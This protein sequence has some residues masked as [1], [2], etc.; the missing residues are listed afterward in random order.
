MIT[1]QDAATGRAHPEDEARLKADFVEFYDAGLGALADAAV[2]WVATGKGF[3]T[4]RERT[5]KA[6]AIPVVPD[7]P[8][9]AKNKFDQVLRQWQGQKYGNDNRQARRAF[10]VEPA[11]FEPECQG[12]FG[13]LL[14]GNLWVTGQTTC[15]A[16]DP[17][18]PTPLVVNDVLVRID[19]AHWSK[20]QRYMSLDA[21]DALLQ[22]IYPGTFPALQHYTKG[23]NQLNAHTIIASL[24]AVE[25]LTRNA[26]AICARFEYSE[27]LVNA[28]AELGIVQRGYTDWVAA[29]LGQKPRQGSTT[30]YRSHRFEKS[31]GNPAIHALATIPSDHLAAQL[32]SGFANASGSAALALA[33]LLALRGA[34]AGR[35]LLRKRLETEKNSTLRE[36]LDRILRVEIEDIFDDETGYVALDGSRV[37]IAPVPAIEPEFT[38]PDSVRVDIERY[39][40]QLNQ[41]IT[42]QNEQRRRWHEDS[43][44]RGQ[45]LSPPRQDALHEAEAVDALLTIAHEGLPRPPRQPHPFHSAI[46]ALKRGPSYSWEARFKAW[47][48]RPLHLLQLVR[49]AD[50][51]LLD[52]FTHPYD[53]IASVEVLRRLTGVLELRTLR[54]AVAA[55]GGE[56]RP[57]ALGAYEDIPSANV[58]P[59]FA[60]HM[61]SIARAFANGGEQ[62]AMATLSRFPKVPKR[63]VP[64]LINLALSEKRAQWSPA[65]T[66]LGDDASLTPL[67]LPQ[68]ESKT[69]ERRRVAAQW[70]G[71]RGDQAAVAP[72]RAA[73]AKEKSALVYAAILN[74][75]KALG[76]ELDEYFD[77]GKL[78]AAAEESLA[79]A[80]P[81]KKGWF[82][83]EALP[84]LFW[85]D[86]RPLKR[87]LVRHWFL[88]A[89]ELKLT[90]D[91]AQ[92]DLYLD[93]LQPA[94]AEALGLYV[95]QAWIARDT[96]PISENDL[97][98]IG[99]EIFKMYQATPKAHG[100]YVDTT[101]ISW[102]HLQEV[103]PASCLVLARQH[104]AGRIVASAY[105]NRG[106]LAIAAR[107]PAMEAVRLIRPYLKDHYKRMSQC[108]ALLDCL[109]AN[110]APAAL[111]LIFATATKSKNKG[112]QKHASTLVDALA[113]ARGW[114]RDELA[115]RTVP[116]AG[117]DEEGVLKL[118]VGDGVYAARMG[119]DLSTVLYN[120]DGVKVAALPTPKDEVLVAD[121]KEAKATLSAAKKELKQ[122]IE[123]QSTRF[124]EALCSE[125]VWSVEDFRAFILQ[126]PILSRLAERLIWLALDVGHK[127]ATTFRPLGDGTLSDAQ[128]RPV[129]LDHAS[130]VQLAH[131]AAIGADHAEAWLRHFSDYE[132]KPLF[133]QLTRPRRTLGPEHAEA[134]SLED[135]QGWAM[136]TFKLRTAATKLGW[137]RGPILDG[138]SF[139]AYEKALPGMGLTAVLSFSGSMVP[140][141]NVRAA[142]HGVRFTRAHANGSSPLLLA[143]VP[144]VLLSEVWNDYHDIA[145][146]GAFD[147]EWE[148]ICP[149]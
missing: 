134:E 147:P 85:A 115:D 65:Q 96:T 49:L 80:D 124:Y 135:R 11:R 53:G 16:Y 28:L 68:L 47:S 95:L 99:A 14:V 72:L 43:K 57:L 60:A 92:I 138:G 66:L 3:E 22:A 23:Q 149:W 132:L 111:Q 91:N 21:K 104:F 107:A 26:E 100:R 122:T 131:L 13:I 148:N 40:V 83:L 10:F 89:N 1:E 143:D 146:A 15:G 74:A 129:T 41:G 123:I 58:W 144:P 19:S 67:I 102:T 120:P 97:E 24:D 105:D 52:A 112:V 69:A 33:D 145:A 133:P 121:A 126:H 94:S 119:S 93:Q 4:L 31:R 77:E 117:F 35:S 114:T 78:L 18:A 61:E 54:D 86:G 38:L 20:T 5:A 50:T 29:G 12:R 136:D 27:T 73:A 39:R 32:G 34:G 118:P 25:Y 141:Q 51:D 88:I 142:L 37:A 75:L 9:G 87:T 128:D 84:D 130:V 125:R 71:K 44:A 36:A 110:G 81:E 7:G 79:K 45:A 98:R 82:P 56:P 63:F 116:T 2:R 70:L 42:G 127:P 101:Y 64:A 106:L 103:T 62:V 140:E 108:K 55:V 8:H 46:Y 30:V 109:A 76:T 48:A 59:Y 137:K 6:G 90:A 17:S 113:E 139:D